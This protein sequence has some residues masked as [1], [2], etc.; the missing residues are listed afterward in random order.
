[1]EHELF[2]IK[3]VLRVPVYEVNKEA[4][5]ELFMHEDEPNELGRAAKWLSSVYV[6]EYMRHRALKA[7]YE[8]Y[9]RRLPAGLGE[10]R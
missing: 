5:F 6:E 9:Q 7:F 10:L 3:K 4:L 1:M 2:V 8:G